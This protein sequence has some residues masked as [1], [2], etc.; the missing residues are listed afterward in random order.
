MEK[1]YFSLWNTGILNSLIDQT[2]IEVYFNYKER[3]KDLRV[4]FNGK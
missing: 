4:F 1:L 2:G 3:I